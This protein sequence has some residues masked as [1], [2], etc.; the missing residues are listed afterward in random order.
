MDVRPTRLA[1]AGRYQERHAIAQRL[2][3]AKLDDLPVEI[4]STWLTCPEEHDSDLTDEQAVARA[5][6]N[7]AEIVQADILLYFPSW[8]WDSL[9][10]WFCPNWSPGRLIDYGYALACGLDIL[11]VGRP[12]PS[13]Y[14]TPHVATV[15]TPKTLRDTLGRVLRID[16]QSN[17]GDNERDVALPKN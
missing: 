14:F 6:Q 8:H 10:K 5:N 9:F 2:N 11:I 17:R 15:C 16:A 12:E 3:D 13:I 7:C 4:T 1:V